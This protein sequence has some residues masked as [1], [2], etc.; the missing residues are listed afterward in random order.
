MDSANE[1]S[2]DEE[3]LEEQEK[4]EGK[5]DHSQELADL[6]VIIFDILNLFIYRRL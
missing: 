1:T 3:T 5:V 4:A 6:E 2:D